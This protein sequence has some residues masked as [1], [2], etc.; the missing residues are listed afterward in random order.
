M[1]SFSALRYALC[2]FSGNLKHFSWDHQVKI[3][4]QRTVRLGRCCMGEFP[5]VRYPLMAARMIRVNSTHQHL[6]KSFTL[7]LPL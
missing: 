5:M 7:S 3:N 1:R 2:I 4:S 6:I